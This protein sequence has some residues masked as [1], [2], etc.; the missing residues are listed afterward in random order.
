MLPF[1]ARSVGSTSLGPYCGDVSPGESH[2]RSD[3]EGHWVWFVTIPAVGDE[4]IFGPQLWGLTWGGGRNAYADGPFFRPAAASFSWISDLFVPTTVGFS[5]TILTFYP[6]PVCYSGVGRLVSGVRSRL[7]PPFR[8]GQFSWKWPGSL[9][10]QQGSCW[11]TS[12]HS[13]RSQAVA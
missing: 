7:L 1:S 13:R 12:R 10:R 5:G 11:K 9:Q 4:A 6:A 3:V 2:A 8:I